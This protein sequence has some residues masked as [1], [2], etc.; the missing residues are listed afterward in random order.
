MTFRTE[1]LSE[2]IKKM[3]SLNRKYLETQKKRK[4]IFLSIL[5]LIWMVAA[6]WIAKA[7]DIVLSG[8]GAG[9][10]VDLK[11]SYVAALKAVLSDGNVR[12]FYLILLLLFVAM[13]LYLSSNIKKDL[14][15]IDTVM[16][17]DDIEIPVAAGNGQHGNERFLK[18][19]EKRELFDVFEYDGHNHY[20]SIEHGGV[21]V[22]MKS[23]KG[24]ETILYVGGEY[25]SIII[26]ASGA[27]KTRRILLETLWLQIISGLSVIISDVK[28]EIYYYSHVY[29]EK[30]KYHTIAFDLRNPKKSA[31]YNF[32]QPILDAFESG[33]QAK[34]IDCVWDLVSVLVGEQKG[35]PIWYNGEC[36][37]IAAALLIVALEAPRE[38]RNLTNV[39]YFLAY[40]C[41]SDAE[42]NMPLNLYLETLPDDHPA[43]GVFAMA[44]IAADK[45]R[46]SFFTSALGT[47]RLFTNPNIADMTAES[48]FKLEDISR[49]KTILYMMIPDE[50]KTYYSL[51]S[52]LITQLYQ[53]QV[54]LANG[55]GLRLPVDTDY[56][57]DEFGNF[58]YIPVAGNIASAGR[59]RGVRMNLVLQDYQQLESKYKEEHANI[60]TNC[61]LKIYLKSDDEKTLKSISETVGKYTVEATSASSSVSDGKNGGNYS[62]SSSLTGRALLEP[63]ELK[64]MKQ[65]YS[66]VMM[67]GEYPGI[68]YLPDLSEWH[69]NKLYGLGD[70]KHNAKLIMEREAFR[71]EREVPP[72][73]LWGIWKQYRDELDELEAER[74]DINFIE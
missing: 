17:T 18:E 45:T 19:S 55:N 30:M 49:N 56:D 43:K 41:Q 73:K 1:R 32:M 16:V 69:L 11:L 72:I 7:L 66:L 47:L 31:R 70:K 71:T 48:D 44:T 65:P 15:T 74:R 29:A 25:H 42:G 12:N 68:G 27:G 14:A 10:T 5:T 36:A 58:P 21:V 50:K 23:R 22:E 13:L 61:Q 63:A 54:D 57:L 51:V 46:A 9:T 39:Y 26:G 3:S 67:T 20:P 28:G 62:T 34:A 53:A 33:D 6:V 59:S 38:Y 64:R 37:T 40:M 60:K 2:G 8:T 4:R 35:E 52:L 24:K